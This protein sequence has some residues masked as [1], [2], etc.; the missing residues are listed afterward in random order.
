M[1][2]LE[3]IGTV[4][5]NKRT[6]EMVIAESGIDLTGEQG[7]VAG[8]WVRQYVLRLDLQ[9]SA[10]PNRL[11]D[12]NKIG[13]GWAIPGPQGDANGTKPTSLLGR[14]RVRFGRR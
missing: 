7:R 1:R 14:M 11:G 10:H 4:Q 8:Q 2:K 13:P 3:F 12:K 6:Q 9:P 5:A